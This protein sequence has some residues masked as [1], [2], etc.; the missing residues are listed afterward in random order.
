MPKPKQL[1]LSR[2]RLLQ[3]SAGASVPTLAGQ[4]SSLLVTPRQTEGPFYPINEQADKDTDLTQIAGKKGQAKGK[5]IY[6]SGEVVDQ[7][8]SPIKNAIVDIWQANTHGKYQH[9][10]DNSDVPVDPYFQ[11]WA[12][13]PADDN[14]KF[15]VK[16]IKPGAYAISRSNMRTPHIHFKVSK[17]GYRSLTS[18]MYFPGEKLNRSDIILRSLSAEKQK[19]LILS[20]TDNVN[21]QFRIVLANT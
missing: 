18:Q 7:Y 9:P 16:T 13:F 11:G 20:T 5:I 6:L 1:N 10:Y 17:N 3:L 4:K 12:V 19:A 8:G 15:S 14:G 2:R 21:F